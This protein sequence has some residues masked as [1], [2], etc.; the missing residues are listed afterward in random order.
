MSDPIF[1]CLSCM[2]LDIECLHED[3]EEDQDD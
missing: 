2:D 1:R 3:V